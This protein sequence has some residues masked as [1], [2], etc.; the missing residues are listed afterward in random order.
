[1]ESLPRLTLTTSA[2]LDSIKSAVKHG[3]LLRAG[4]V[5]LPSLLDL[6][7]QFLRLSS[8]TADNSPLLGPGNA[9]GVRAAG[10]AHVHRRAGGACIQQGEQPSL[11]IDTT[12]PL[13]RLCS[14]AVWQ[15]SL[16][17][18]LAWADSRACC[19][20]RQNLPV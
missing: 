9:G 20:G 14:K 2:V 10:V 11:G 3:W 7:T 1:M 6:A 16:Q 4:A 17:A 15:D 5:S 18:E 13:S 8:A 12:T 19:Q